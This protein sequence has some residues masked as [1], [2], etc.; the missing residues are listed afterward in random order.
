MKMYCLTGLEVGAPKPRGQ[1]GHTHASRPPSGAWF[2]AA[3]LQ[4]A[5]GIVPECVSGFRC[6]LLI[7]TLVV[8]E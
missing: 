8:L 4:P 6:P 5:R 2:M 3:Y 7:K 1:W